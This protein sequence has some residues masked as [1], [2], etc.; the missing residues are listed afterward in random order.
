MASIFIPAR[1]CVYSPNASSGGKGF[2]ALKPPL[3]GTAST[4][5]LIEG[6]D[7]VMN[8]IV[9]PVAT[10]DEKKF[11]FVMGDDF[12][13]VSVN[14]LALLGTHDTGGQSFAAVK[15]YF[16][17]NRSSKS[18]KPIIAS[19]PGGVQVQFYL[20]GL[21]VARADPEYNVQFFQL[22]GVVVEPSSAGGG[23][24]RTLLGRARQ[25]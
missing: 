13:N 15:K 14:G 23:A 11:F 18:K 1:G 12:G 5:I 20:T 21:T 25:T 22:R 4:P 19:C 6:V 2:Y 9:F 24:G 7:A 16:D 8:D 3:R 10:L 17:T